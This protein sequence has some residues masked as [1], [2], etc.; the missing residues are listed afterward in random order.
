KLRL[1][2]L[3]A[4]SSISTAKVERKPPVIS[5]PSERPPAP[6]NRSSVRNASINTSGVPVVG[7]R[8]VASGRPHPCRV[9]HRPLTHHHRRGPKSLAGLARRS[10]THRQSRPDPRGSWLNQSHREI[11]SAGSVEHFRPT[12]HPPRGAR[13][14][15]R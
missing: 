7:A 4:A 15:R 10:D 14:A 13:S 8:A 3:A 12:R 11:Y 9:N 2:V 6:A 5:K 1:N